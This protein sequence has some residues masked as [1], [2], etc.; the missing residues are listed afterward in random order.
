M[1]RCIG[2]NEFPKF[3]LPWTKSYLLLS[4]TQKCAT[5]SLGELACELCSELLTFLEPLH[6]GADDQAV[7]F[8]I[9]NAPRRK[10][11]YRL[12]SVGYSLKS[13]VQRRFESSA[14]APGSMS[15]R[16]PRTG[17]H[18]CCSV[19]ILLRLVGRSCRAARKH[20]SVFGSNKTA[21]AAKCK[22]WDA[23][24][25]PRTAPSWSPTRSKVK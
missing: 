25:E 20:A 19:P 2:R 4:S 14:G 11:L 18:L 10:S 3:V 16:S 7:V 21:A 13:P 9:F 17:R 15:A 5:I 1:V 8:L 23:R 24:A 22:S 6:P 12:H